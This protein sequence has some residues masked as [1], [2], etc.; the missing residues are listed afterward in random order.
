MKLKLFKIKLL[1]NVDK[2]VNTYNIE[3]D[4]YD[5]YNNVVI[6]EEDGVDKQYVIDTPLILDTSIS[7]CTESIEEESIIFGNMLDV[8]KEHIESKQKQ[9][10]YL[11]E[12][13][14]TVE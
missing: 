6:L 1:P 3:D 9:L 7:L 8:L 2:E 5:S 11:Q 10:N 4:K 13:I 14:K 12:I